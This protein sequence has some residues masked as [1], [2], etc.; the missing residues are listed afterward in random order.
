MSKLQDNNVQILL[1]H[2]QALHVIYRQ[3]QMEHQ[4]S[5]LGAT[6]SKYG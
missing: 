5:K 1:E 3:T 4:P 2:L 6:M